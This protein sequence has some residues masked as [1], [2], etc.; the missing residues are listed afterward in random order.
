[1]PIFFLFD[2]TMSPALV[3]FAA[4]LAADFVA[5][6]VEAAARY[7]PAVAASEASP[8]DGVAVNYETVLHL[9]STLH[10]EW[11]LVWL[12]FRLAPLLAHFLHHASKISLFRSFTKMG[13]ASD[14]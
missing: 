12:D 4:C 13:T 1:M 7:T 8:K 9:H 14:G 3:F 6:R 2:S 10:Q 5:E 11:C